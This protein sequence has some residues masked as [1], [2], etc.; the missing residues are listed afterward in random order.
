MKR[1]LLI[2]RRLPALAIPVLT[3][4]AL[5][6]QTEVSGS[7]RGRVLDEQG[8]PVYGAV[9][10]TS[11]QPGLA[12]ESA[13]TVAQGE[14]KGDGSFELT[15]LNPGIYR[16]C[17][18]QMG[19]ALLDPCEWSETPVTVQLSRGGVLEGVDVRVEFGEMLRI[20][21][22]D[23]QETLKAEEA[24][25]KRKTSFLY[26]A[27]RSRAGNLRRARLL[28]TTAGG[29]ELGVAAPKDREAQLFVA[30]HN[31]TLKDGLGRRLRETGETITLPKQPMPG[32]GM[33]LLRLEPAKGEP[34]AP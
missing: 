26:V 1:I 30:G 12:A 5:F 24:A 10:Q 19:S 8:R 13:L 31:L 22:E 9:V 32:A 4:A 2:A 11:R 7:I 27:I 14:S 28:R 34:A 16:L 18:Q 33:N 3:G 6:A 29:Y 21:I 17:V 15:G 20:A 23:P 25:T